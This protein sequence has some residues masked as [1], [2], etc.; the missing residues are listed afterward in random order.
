MNLQYLKNSIFAENEIKIKELGNRMVKSNILEIIDIIK[1]K[2]D[3]MN[4]SND[5]YLNV[6]LKLNDDII[7][8]INDFIPHQIILKQIMY[9]ILLKHAKLFNDFLTLQK[10]DQ[11]YY[12]FNDDWEYNY[13]T[14]LIR[15]TKQVY[16][17]EMNIIYNKFNISNDDIK[18][19]LK[20][21]IIMDIN[22]LIVYFESILAKNLN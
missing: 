2:C 9:M 18:L 5:K 11:I 3:N 10:N 21:K 14:D 15:N 17:S 20:M 1:K 8:T 22:T 16:M 6:S 12:M 7:S 19:K 4:K 13:S